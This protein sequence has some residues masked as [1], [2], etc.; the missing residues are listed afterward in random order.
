M[1]AENMI[2]LTD[3]EPSWILDQR[4]R[5]HD[6]KPNINTSAHP[7][8][9][10]LNDK[11]YV[12]DTQSRIN[13]RTG[14]R[15]WQYSIKENTWSLHSRPELASSPGAPIFSM[16]PLE[17]FGFKE[18]TLAVFH[19]QL[20]CIGGFKK[21]EDQEKYTRIR[22]VYSWN[23]RE[24]K[25]SDVQQIPEDVEL[26]SSDEI[27]ASSDDTRL[28]LAWQ[29]DKKVQILH[30]SRQR[31]WERKEGPDC[32]SSDSRIEISVLNET[33]FLT[34]HNDMV[35]TMI[36]KASVSSLF[37]SSASGH[38]IWT[39]INWAPGIYRRDIEPYQFFSNLT[40]TPGG[41]IMLLTPS[42]DRRSS[43]TAM[44]YN[45]E[46]SKSSEHSYWE[47]IGCL[48]IEWK[49]DS[50]PSIFGLH[51]ETLLIISPEKTR[52]SLRTSTSAK[53]CVTVHKR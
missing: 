47:T 52:Y 6:I 48:P 45:L 53:V 50:H 23:G 33:M 21:R 51:N 16:Q 12:R 37:S 1:A 40:V 31:K 17:P 28:Y 2:Q 10:L 7:W 15:I 5:S 4:H 20:V 8:A 32:K 3:Q 13:S 27:S 29:K 49:P 19:S 42:P 34:E 41:N 46:N 26:P 25:D 36:R 30:Y 22:S 35:R 38:S 44:L 39:E 11:V 24:W 9:V 18:Y 14:D 43:S